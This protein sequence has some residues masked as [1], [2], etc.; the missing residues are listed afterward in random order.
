M[1]KV[2]WRQL[3]VLDS[4]MS[5]LEGLESAQQLMAQSCPPQPGTHTVVLSHLE[6]TQRTESTQSQGSSAP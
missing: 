5:L 3:F 4:M 2:L 1:Q 6:R